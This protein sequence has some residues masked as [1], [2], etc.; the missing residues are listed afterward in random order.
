MRGIVDENW[1]RLKHRL[2]DFW[3]KLFG[4]KGR[5]SW[6]GSNLTPGF[7]GIYRCLPRATCAQSCGFERPRVSGGHH[8]SID[9]F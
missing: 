5:E 3:H 1:L 4:E 8:A 9:C 6:R 7:A 2:K